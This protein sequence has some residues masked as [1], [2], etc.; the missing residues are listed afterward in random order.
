M[1]TTELEGT[2]MRAPVRLKNGAEERPAIVQQVMRVLH[3]LLDEPMDAIAGFELCELAR[4][5]GHVP[6]GNAGDKL[7]ATGLVTEADGRYHMHDSIRNVLVSACE[8]DGADMAI[9]NPL[10]ANEGE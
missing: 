10:S 8:G 1:A 9:V 2:P 6:F 7:L 3:N 4:N 5:R